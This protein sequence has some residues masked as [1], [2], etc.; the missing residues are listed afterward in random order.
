VGE[1]RRQTQEGASMSWWAVFWLVAIAI[2]VLLY[3]LVRHDDEN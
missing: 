2:V 3:N 1:A